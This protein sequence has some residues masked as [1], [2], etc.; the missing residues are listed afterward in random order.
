M[1]LLLML[2]T[3][4]VLRAESS[5]AEKLIEAGHWK[6]A[7]VEVEARYRTAPGDALSNFLLSQIRGA[8]GD[9]STPLTLAEKA[10]ALDPRTAKYH[11]QIAEVLG[12]TAQHSGA[13]QQLLLA[14]RF[15]KEIELALACDARDLQSRRDLL[16][17][18]LLAPGIAGGDVRKAE[19]VA[20][21]IAQLDA[22]EGLLAQSRL[23]EFRKQPAV[24]ENLLRQV[25]ALPQ[26]RYK[27]RITLAQYD[28]EPTHTNLNIAEEQAKAAIALDPGR[29]DAYA[30]LATVYAERAEW[31]KL[32]SILAA[33]AREVPDDAAPYYRAAE[34]LLS[35][36]RDAVRA[37]Q[38]L[39]VY[40]A[41]EPEGNQPGAAEARWKLG[42]AL[43]MQ[44]RLPEA[45]AAFQESV[46]LDPE[47]KAAQELKRLRTSAA[48]SAS[49]SMRPM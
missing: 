10:A 45:R 46:R 32:E 2:T 17:F 1:R 48:G 24:R 5:P 35:A 25:A 3:F 11:R 37:E 40:L 19:E 18:Y 31:T 30:A 28:L 13:F 41:Q 49:N 8:F 34:H 21:Q 38:Y 15:R 36:G 4:A 33:A 14:R 22:G 43:E 29:I 47:S 42:L 39:R 20:A 16:E 23:A 27:T 7:R 12:I 26:P 44:G 6:R 9:R